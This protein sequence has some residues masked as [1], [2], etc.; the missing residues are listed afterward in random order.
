MRQAA[1]SRCAIYAHAHYNASSVLCA[2]HSS[3]T[4]SKAFCT[5]EEGSDLNDAAIVRISGAFIIG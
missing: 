5:L 4:V 2:V 3:K 1:Q